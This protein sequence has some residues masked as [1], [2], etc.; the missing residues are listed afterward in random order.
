MSPL[1]PGGT[2]PPAGGG[3]TVVDGRPRMIM[4]LS[5]RTIA[6]RR[7]RRTRT[8]SVHFRDTNARRNQRE[9]DE[10]A[11]AKR[12]PS[13]R[14]TF[15]R[16]PSKDVWDPLSADTR[17]LPLFRMQFI[18]GRVGSTSISNVCNFC[19]GSR[20]P[21]L[22]SSGSFR[23]SLRC[24]DHLISSRKNEG[25]MIGKDHM[26]RLVGPAS[27]LVAFS[28]TSRAPAPRTGYARS[29]Q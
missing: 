8:N 26:Q 27:E 2:E 21:R 19:C 6:A 29:C 23:L 3:G 15:R 12:T 28:S 25:S 14:S 11:R 24:V 1:V 4:I 5:H 9:R 13:V 20:S 22:S 16:F 10:D 18:M 17:N 7:T